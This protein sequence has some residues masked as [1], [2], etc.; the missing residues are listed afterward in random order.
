MIHFHFLH[1]IFIHFRLV[2]L[3][4]YFGNSCS[5]F[6][7]PQD[8]FTCL[9]SNSYRWRNV[10]S[11]LSSV[12][13]YWIFRR[14][15]L[16]L[17]TSSS[18]ITTLAGSDTMKCICIFETVLILCYSTIVVSLLCLVLLLRVHPLCLTWSSITSQP[19]ISTSPSTS[20]LAHED[21]RLPLIWWGRW[22]LGNTI[23][24]YVCKI[25]HMYNLRWDLLKSKNV[26]V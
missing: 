13:L 16:S 21:G 5:S 24:C 18:W 7:D 25:L 17:Q 6:K 23:D 22:E 1:F 8:V 11:V 19:R 10:S 14:M 3:S 9:C 20:T 15:S 12:V 26:S 2:Q 4:W